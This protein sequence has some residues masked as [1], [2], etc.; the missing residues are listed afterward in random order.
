[1]G[2]VALMWVVLFALAWFLER[3]VLSWYFLIIPVVISFKAIKSYP[4]SISA[5]VSL[6]VSILSIVLYIWFTS[7]LNVSFS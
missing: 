3:W 7:L 5:W 2:V 4:K 1:M 6:I